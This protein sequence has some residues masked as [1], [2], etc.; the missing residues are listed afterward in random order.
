MLVSVQFIPRF[1]AHQ[2]TP[3]LIV[4]FILQISRLESSS[5]LLYYIWRLNIYALHGPSL[6][7]LF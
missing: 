1:L 6:I 5:P 7:I 4:G 3:N 2:E